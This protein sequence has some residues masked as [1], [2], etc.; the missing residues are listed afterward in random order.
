MR[1]ASARAPRVARANG[2]HFGMSPLPPRFAIAFGIAALMI[3][4]GLFVL[5]R[6][7]GTGGRGVTGPA[8]LDV[9]FALFF[10]L[11]GAMSLATTRRQLR[12]ERDRQPP[13]VP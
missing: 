13:S 11:R 5:G 7:I 2:A 6:L 8:W 9:A 12:R 10:L 3:G 1:E 4:L